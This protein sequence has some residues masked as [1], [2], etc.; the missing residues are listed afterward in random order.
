[1]QVDDRGPGKEKGFVDSLPPGKELQPDR[2]MLAVLLG[3]CAAILLNFPACLCIF[4]S[5]LT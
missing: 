2:G 4:V 1:V 5:F 3:R